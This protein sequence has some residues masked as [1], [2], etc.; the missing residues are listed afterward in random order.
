M[1]PLDKYEYKIRAEE[2]K[3][4]I[5]QKKY[6]EAAKVADTIDWT[7]VKSVMML[8]TVS[9]VYKV[10]RRFEDA[11]LLLEMANERHPSGRM[12]IYSLC[13]LSIR[14]GDVVHA[15]EYYKD[16]VQ[17]APN[18]SGRY[19]LQ[20]KL[21]EAQDVGL[22]ERIAVLEELKKKDYREK[23]AYEL[24]YLYH[25]V[26]LA[27]KCVEECDELILWFGEGKYVMK[28]MEL[29]TLHQPLSPS[30]QK[31]FDAYMMRRQGLRVPEEPEEDAAAASRPEKKPTG[32]NGQEMDIQVKTMDVGKYNTINLQKELA[33]SMQELM[34][35]GRQAATAVRTAP[36]QTPQEQVYTEPAHQ[37]PEYTGQVYQE[38]SW[39]PSETE[40]TGQNV[41]AS[42][43]AFPATD[44][45]A[46]EEVR[47]AEEEE[48]DDIPGEGYQHAQTDYENYLSQEYDGQISMVVPEERPVEKQITGQMNIEDIM[49]E[50]EKMKR[51]NEEKRRQELRQRV[52]EQTGALFRD[53]DE[54]SRKGVLE[55]LQKE[56]R[57]PVD[58]RAR[59]R[60]TGG[61][62][63]AHTK[64][65][66]AEEVQNAM[67]AAAAAGSAE[68]E[69]MQEQ[70]KTPETP[71]MPAAP[72]A[73]PATAETPAVQE[74]PAVQE[75]SAIPRE[76]AVLEEKEQKP[77]LESIVPE[78]EEQPVRTA[79][80]EQKERQAAGKPGEGQKTVQPAGKKKAEGTEG[81]RRLSSAEKRLFASFVPTKGA[82][83]RLVTALDQISLAAYTGN[84]II[85]GEPG[86]DTL[87]LAKNVVKDLKA[88]NPD[89]S[90]RIAKI[91]GSALSGSKK[92]PEE[93]VEKLA[94]GVLMIEKAGEISEECAK[95]LQQ[96]LNQER[97]GIL[98]ILMDT[99]RRIRKLL[100]ENPE[101]ASFF[102]ARFDVEALDNSTL[103]AYGCQYARMQEYAIDELG[104]LAL[105]TRIEDM[106]TSDHI[107]TVKD[108]REIVDDAIDHAERKTP[109]HFMDVLLSRRY[110]D[111][112]MIILHEG[113]FI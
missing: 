67:K 81:D 76:S 1:T 49:R 43:E 77:V 4:L 80:E 63:S 100:E 107:V 88:K 106:Q 73:A 102:N 2:I 14:M 11:K 108:V 97:W 31:K 112:D 21:Y 48:G 79:K 109:K 111:N 89:F 99:K 69:K 7:R 65:W 24:A 29:K 46:V 113:D 78:R 9:D 61:V 90:G 18:D 87:E 105:H 40:Y 36:A 12:I 58:R 84:L 82:M 34:Q 22:E 44:Y 94:G 37:E 26:G 72:A 8:C 32:R 19:V 15:I 53:F 59:E 91:T 42:Y 103:V 75:V 98:V 86:S 62:I 96:A 3:T 66:A 50:W 110:D 83:K 52:Q 93:L 56:E 47:P 17:I 45:T 28:A 16:F 33:A 54:T 60:S 104:R 23:W 85:T 39:Q 92:P 68:K 71:E 74:A 64:I 101:M 70:V 6:A 35:E 51:E 41:E 25:R 95:K 55:R 5:S 38:P 57:I 10:N 20:Y 30:Q 13:D 27:T